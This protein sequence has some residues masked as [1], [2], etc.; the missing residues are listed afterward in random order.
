MILLMDNYDSFTYNIYQYF[1]EEKK[2]VHVVRNDQITLSE[3]EGLQPEAIVISPGPGLPNQTGICLTMVNALYKQIPILGI[4]LG[5]QI[6]AQSLGGS[7][8]KAKEIKHGKTSLITHKASGLFHNLPQP[9]EVMRYHSF[10]VD[11]KT[12][13]EDLEVTATS[14]EDDEI[15]AIQHYKY[16]VYGVQFHPESIGTIAGK[17][18]IRNFLYAIRKESGVK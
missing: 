11:R 4:C 12:L 1:S 9:L 16:P 5:E 8:T 10:V 15:M 14:L 18:L 2:E 7:V 13:P 6:I 3:I 17:Q